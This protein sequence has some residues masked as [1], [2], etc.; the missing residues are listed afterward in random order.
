LPIAN[1]G[2]SSLV[3]WQLKIGNSSALFGTKAMSERRTVAVLGASRD[4]R[5][6]GNKSLRAHRQGGFEVFPINLQSTEIEGLSAY[7]SLRDVPVRPIDR[8]TVYV[9][10]E[11]GLKLLNDIA[12][13]RPREVWFNPGSESPELV[14]AANRMGLPVICGCSIVDLGMSPSMFPDS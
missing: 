11:V 2:L 6:F 4:R 1:C 5:K 7:R 10:P 9:P 3:D 12:E 14:A 8:V 13:C